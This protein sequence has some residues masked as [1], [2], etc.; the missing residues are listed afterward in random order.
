MDEESLENLKEQVEANTKMMEAIL[1]A[2]LDGKVRYELSESYTD[3]EE[4]TRSVNGNFLFSKSKYERE[5][6]KL[7]VGSVEARICLRTGGK[8]NFKTGQCIHEK[9]KS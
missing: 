7:M 9:V 2:L 4:E 6:E 1:S 5:T 8:Y 3:I